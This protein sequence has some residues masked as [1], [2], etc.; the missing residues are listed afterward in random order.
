M[1]RNYY[2]II[3]AS[4]RY[5]SNISA[6]AK[7]L[8]GEITALCNDKGYCWATNEY[9]ADLYDTS[10]R[11]I[12]RWLTDLKDAGY[13]CTEDE[14]TSRKIYIVT[15]DKNVTGGMTKMSRGDDK[16]VTHNNT[17]NITENNTY[18]DDDRLNKAFAEYV[19][20]K[21]EIGKPMTAIGIEKEKDKLIKLA[22]TDIDTAIAIIEQTIT[23]SWATLYPLSKAKKSVKNFTERDYNW[24]ELEE[25]LFNRKETL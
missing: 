6:N 8:F 21:D 10:N 15:G 13:I 17:E 14:S 22:N 18:F 20:Y 1:G 11:T 12:Q 24:D 3:P 9:F 23:K 16:N 7:L 19:T 5:D 4:V 2:A 25:Q